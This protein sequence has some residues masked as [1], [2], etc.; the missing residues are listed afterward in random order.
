VATQTYHELIYRFISLR[1]RRIIFRYL[2]ASRSRLDDPS[3]IF[4]TSSGAELRLEDGWLGQDQ[5]KKN[6]KSHI[7]RETTLICEK[8]VFS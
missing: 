8:C 2:D 3:R 1:G 4:G 5:F 6:Q 7:P